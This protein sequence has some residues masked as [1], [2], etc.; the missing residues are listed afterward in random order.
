MLKLLLLAFSIIFIDCRSLSSKNCLRAIVDPDEAGLET[1][2]Y[3][4][5]V[6]VNA[7]DLLDDP[8]VIPF[9]STPDDVT[10]SNPDD[11]VS[12]IAYS[13]QPDSGSTSIV[14]GNPRPSQE[15]AEM[16]DAERHSL[17]SA[18]KRLACCKPK[19]SDA[20]RLRSRISD[21]PRCIWDSDF[22][23]DYEPSH[24]AIHDWCKDPHLACCTADPARSFPLWSEC[25]ALGLPEASDSPKPNASC[26]SHLNTGP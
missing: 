16:T 7:P 6:G 19:S 11:L 17:C 13:N 4:G 22:A 3:S 8:N 12:S 10:I 15:I 25:E 18:N 23:P 9:L 5:L 24:D 21:D 26:R 20:W 2:A 14:L 1:D